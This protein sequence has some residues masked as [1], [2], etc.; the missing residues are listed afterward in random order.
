MRKNTFKVW[1]AVLA[2]IIGFEAA[3]PELVLRRQD[4]NAADIVPTV[5]AAGNAGSAAPDA[6][7]AAAEAM[8]SVKND[9]VY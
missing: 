8:A 7:S 2:F 6:A 9:M 3:S 1:S 4:A 5:T